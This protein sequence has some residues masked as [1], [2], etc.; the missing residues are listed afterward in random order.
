MKQ[1]I[2]TRFLPRSHFKSEEQGMIDGFVLAFLIPGTIFMSLLARVLFG[3]SKGNLLVVFNSAA[4]ASSCFFLSKL[5]RRTIVY[6]LGA[7]LRTSKKKLGPTR[8]KK[9]GPYIIISIYGAP[10]L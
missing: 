6:W 9:K 5:I 2:W 1:V 3:V 10:I 7:V 4:G 8:R